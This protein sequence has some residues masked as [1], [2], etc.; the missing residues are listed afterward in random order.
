MR[1]INNR[2]IIEDVIS[3]YDDFSNYLVRDLEDEK[4][5][6]V[7]ILENNVIKEKVKEYLLTK[8]KTSY[9]LNFEGIV[10]LK[11]SL[12]V[13]NIDGIKLTDYK[14][15]YITEVFFGNR[16]SYEYIK[17]TSF[18]EKIDIFIKICEIV[19]T[20]NI[21]GYKFNKI[22]IKDILI[23][24]KNN[25]ELII[26]LNNILEDEFRRLNIIKRLKSKENN[27]IVHTRYRNNNLLDIMDLF[28]IIFK[29]SVKVISNEKHNDFVKKQ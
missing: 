20:L 12:I 2:Y 17:K 16:N 24:K 19:N 11:D 7:Y 3:Y 22:N 29:E 21:K 5:Y 14:V 8:F 28:E 23:Y 1:I 27:F 9:N 26:K 6:S 18:E 15:G 4:E 25:G 13:K 10:N